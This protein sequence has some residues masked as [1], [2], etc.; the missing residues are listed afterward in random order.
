[1]HALEVCRNF[2]YVRFGRDS[3]QWAQCEKCYKWRKVP[4]E[5]EVPAN[6]NCRQNHWDPLRL[7]CSAKEEL[8][9]DMIKK[10][11]LGNNQGMD[12][13]DVAFLYF[14]QASETSNIQSALLRPAGCSKKIK[15]GNLEP[16]SVGI[17]EDAVDVTP[18]ENVVTLPEPPKASKKHPRH[19]PGCTCIVCMQ[20]PSGTKHKP[21]CVC[22]ACA[23]A[24]RRRV[25]NPRRGKKRSKNARL[26]PD[27]RKSSISKQKTQKA[28]TQMEN[29]PKPPEIGS[30][31]SNLQMV[32]GGG[33]EPDQYTKSSSG[34]GVK[35]SFDLNLPPEPDE[36]DVDAV[37]PV[38]ENPN[39]GGNI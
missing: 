6:W 14:D 23:T 1:M 22:C 24:R 39:S 19:R 31:K 27:K 25:L 4:V 33:P 7:R 29:I 5:A 11:F 30:S 2:I 8:T 12:N 3:V 32:V 18:A 35:R 28:P 26:M 21:S 37:V 15:T 36:D 38:L 9:R 13:V 10:I 17:V 20:A 16:V 34:S